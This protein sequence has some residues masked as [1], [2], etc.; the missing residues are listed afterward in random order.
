MNEMWGVVLV[1]QIHHAG[2]HPSRMAEELGQNRSHTSFCVKDDTQGP[3]FVKLLQRSTQGPVLTWKHGDLHR[4]C[5]VQER[6]GA[7][8][9]PKGAPL[10]QLHTR[11]PPGKH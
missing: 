6:E 5:A 8:P 3:V 1:L 4:F 11:S 9:G 7:P 2:P 10:L